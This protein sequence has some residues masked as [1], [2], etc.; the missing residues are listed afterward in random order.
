MITIVKHGNK[1]T[2]YGTCINCGCEI[3]CHEEDVMLD[4]ETTGMN[5]HVICPECGNKIMLNQSI[6]YDAGTIC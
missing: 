5:K 4:T 6:S 3:T 2:Y 1:K